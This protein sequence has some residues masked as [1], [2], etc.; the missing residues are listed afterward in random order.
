LPATSA[1]S[2]SP[3]NAAISSA[4]SGLDFELGRTFDLGDPDTARLFTTQDAAIM[5][6]NDLAA[7]TSFVVDQD[8]DG[9]NAA[10]AGGGDC[11]DTDAQ[12]HGLMIDASADGK[13]QDC[14]G[15]DGPGAGSAP[16]EATATVLEG[17]SAAPSA[18]DPD[19]AELATAAA[20]G[21]MTQTGCA[22]T[23]GRSGGAAGLIAGLVGLLGALRRRPRA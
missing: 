18:I 19:M 7:F 23:G 9:I 17:G 13:D 11:D 6:I 3:G 2:G 5:P 21:E 1:L 20:D 4:S 16:D 10:A 8:G 14:D 22:T 12:V 15:V